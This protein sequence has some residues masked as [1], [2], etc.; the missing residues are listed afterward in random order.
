MAHIFNGGFE[1]KTQKFG[2][3]PVRLQQSKTKVTTKSINA[4]A[5]PRLYQP[6]AAHSSSSV[7]SNS[8][9]NAKSSVQKNT[10][11]TT[12]EI[13][14]AKINVIVKEKKPLTVSIIFKIIL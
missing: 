13:E 2:P 3:P 12:L 14:S 5:K 7:N 10:K 11:K 6:K 9:N 1:T 4:N 8:T